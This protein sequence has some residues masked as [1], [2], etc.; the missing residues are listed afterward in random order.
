MNNLTY[1][2]DVSHILLVIKPKI[3]YDNSVKQ[4][5]Y[6]RRGNKME[7]ATLYS[8]LTGLVVFVVMLIGFVVVNKSGLN[9][10]KKEANSIVEDANEK[11]ESILR[12]AHLEAK[13]QAYEIKLNAEKEQIEKN[14]AIQ[15]VANKLNLRE[16]TINLRD[17]NLVSKEDEI[18]KKQRQ[19]EMRQDKLD[20]TEEEL[21]ERVNA[22]LEEL[23]RIGSISA[24]EAKAE[25]F[26]I[27]EKKM[28]L[29]VLGYIKEQ[30]EYA[31][32][33]ADEISRN[34]IA[35]A[36]SRY[37]Q[38][39]VIQNTSSI[40]SLPNEDMKGR[41]IGREGRNIR[42]FEQATGVDLLIDDTPEMITVSSF[43]PVRREVAKMALETLMSDGRIQPGRIEE[44]VE[45]ARRELA[46][47]VQKTGQKTIFDLG[48]SKM[49]KEIVNVLGKLKYR[50]SYG[51]NVLQ[52]SIEVAHLTGMMAAELG[53]NQR[54]A[55]R[56][57]LLHDIGKG[58]DFEMEGTHVELGTR[59]AK[60]HGEHPLV[61]NAIASHHGDVEATSAI[62]VL[63]AAADTLSSA[64]PGARFESFE[65]YIQRLEDL[66]NVAMSK[67]G[68]AKAF[69]IQA[70]RELRVMV[71]P[72]DLD[73]NET[74]K[75]SRQIKEE[76]EETMTYPGQ[77][78]VTVIRE[79]RAME[80]AK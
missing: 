31:Q 47:I 43:D 56:A 9:K 38:D 37:S 54:L 1:K 44:V 29:E 32:E 61:V 71:V 13:T 67:D 11:S 51:Q 40:I 60:K 17:K 26:D 58:M 21:N 35:L 30:E 8:V 34:I 79:L 70:G 59:L 4:S 52:H 75:L 19:L 57:G 68:V 20:K 36:I 33:K 62:A 24:D 50:Y 78:K 64:R 53:F 74:F 76:I 65:N 42:A 3:K 7:T 15:E 10:S 80:I 25:L 72:E 48:L 5:K 69:A 27:V 6:R 28:E 14:Q 66:E 16:E 46:T 41:I 45:K 77:I 39:M 55:R 49:D 2:L 63:V 12:Q 22:Q 73:D 18:A 23:E